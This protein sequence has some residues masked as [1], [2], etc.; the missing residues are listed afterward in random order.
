MST[1]R[2]PAQVISIRPAQFRGRPVQGAATGQPSRTAPPAGPKPPGTSGP[3]GQPASQSAAKA[4]RD[5]DCL[6]YHPP[7]E[8]RLRRRVAVISAIVALVFA[9]LAVGSV[10]LQRNL[11]LIPV[12]SDL[13]I[14]IGLAVWPGL[15]PLGVVHNAIIAGVAVLFFLSVTSGHVGLPGDP[16]LADTVVWRRQVVFVLPELL[17]CAVLFAVGIALEVYGW[18]IPAALI[19]GPAALVGI[20]LCARAFVPISRQFLCVELDSRNGGLA[21][22]ITVG[23]GFRGIR[24]GTLVIRHERL[25]DAEKTSSF[26]EWALGLASLRLVYLDSAGKQAQIVVRAVAAA[27][28]VQK[29]EE[30]LKGPFRLG[31]KESSLGI[32][33]GHS[34]RNSPAAGVTSK[35]GAT[36]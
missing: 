8:A 12:G 3:G 25:V 10:L 7:G 27:H 36:P 30:I 2:T 33:V 20:R 29:I 15:W 6:K 19:E 26:L 22:R 28:V 14:E 5:R 11:L 17:L 18:R 4:P 13:L 35:P 21:N 32:P 9:G 24:R 1:N 16:R 34:L 31:L 23:G